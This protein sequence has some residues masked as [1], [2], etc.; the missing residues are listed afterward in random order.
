MRSV[1][2]AFAFFLASVGSAQAQKYPVELNC[3]GVGQL[4]KKACKIAKKAIKKSRTWS[5]KKGGPRYAIAM[6]NM[7]A[8]GGVVA[9]GGAYAVVLDDPFTEQFP[10]Y[11]AL[12]S[13]ALTSEQL[14]EDFGPF[15][16]KTLDEARL[17]F[18]GGGGTLSTG[19][20]GIQT[21][22]FV[23]VDLGGPDSS[24]PDQ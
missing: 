10:H 11:L 16:V 12:L 3:T 18:E 19:F 4:G 24:I 13:G 15:V 9:V 8:G 6:L 1:L 21:L 20:T 14:E 2:L 7:D 23:F 17:F 22:R 5:F